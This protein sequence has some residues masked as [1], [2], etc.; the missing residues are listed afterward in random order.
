MNLYPGTLLSKS[1]YRFTFLTALNGNHVVRLD[2]IDLGA[3]EPA[4]RRALNES[5]RIEDDQFRVC[6]PD[7]IHQ[8]PHRRR[9]LEKPAS[10]RGRANKRDIGGMYFGK[11]LYPFADE[12][13]PYAAR[14]ADLGLAN[15][16]VDDGDALACM[17]RMVCESRRE[18]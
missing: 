7:V 4:S 16:G 14:R 5:G 17:H 11:R 2:Q 12:S 8:P 13:G 9:M 15:V 10:W 1:E 3:L 18:R 6:R